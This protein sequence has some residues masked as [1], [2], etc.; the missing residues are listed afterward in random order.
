MDSLTQIVLGAACG[1]LSLG[2]KIGNKAMFWGGIGGTIP[3]LDVFV[4]RWIFDKEIDVL[5]YHRGF[6]HSLLF[7]SSF[8]LVLAALVFYLNRKWLG[9]KNKTTYKEWYW[10]FFWSMIT[11]PILDTFTAYGTQLLQPFSDTRFAISN[12]SVVDLFYTLPFLLALIVAMFYKRNSAKRKGWTIAGIFISSVYMLFTLFNQQH[13]KNIV[14][15]SVDKDIEIVR[16]QVQ[17]SLFTNFLWYAIIDTPEGYQSAM[18]S[19]FDTEKRF[20][21]WIQIPKI[22]QLPD[23]IMDCDYVMNRLK[24]FSNDYFYIKR[25]NGKNIFNDLRYPLREEKEKISVFSFEIIPDTPLGCDIEESTP[26]QP[27]EA[28]EVIQK[29]WQRL[30]GK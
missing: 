26:P 25:L 28:K 30:K 2:K 22:H 23:S 5:A 9:N 18:Y 11:H 14:R 24:W 21:N 10:L 27:T 16:M 20:K 6:M 8:P 19:E 17:P 3:D 12:I 15:N 7:C 4:G 1:E 29:M 13:I